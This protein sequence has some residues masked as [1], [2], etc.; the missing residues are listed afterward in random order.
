MWS[1]VL[2]ALCFGGCLRYLLAAPADLQPHADARNQD[3]F[4]FAQWNTSAFGFL[5]P[6]SWVMLS[7]SSVVKHAV[8][9]YLVSLCDALRPQ[10]PN[11]AW[12]A[13]G[14]V[15]GAE[16]TPSILEALD[17]FSSALAVSWERSARGE[18]KVSEWN[19]K[20]L[21]S[22]WSAE[23]CETFPAELFLWGHYAQESHTKKM[24]RKPLR[25]L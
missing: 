17:I 9:L 19:P 1:F 13:C 20:C 10:Y 6:R 11:V 5:A 3:N 12:G 18:L 4:G 24:K 25:A 8:L 7:S 22:L 14:E 2:H 15:A 21:N 23:K 16:P